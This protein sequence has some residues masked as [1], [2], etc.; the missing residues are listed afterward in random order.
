MKLI[1]YVFQITVALQNTLLSFFLKKR[2]RELCTSTY[3]YVKILVRCYIKGVQ[4]RLPVIL[5]LPGALDLIAS[6]KIPIAAFMDGVADARG[7][8]FTSSYNR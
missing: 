8:D 1:L 6:S 3:F 7:L 5:M 2:E 4:L